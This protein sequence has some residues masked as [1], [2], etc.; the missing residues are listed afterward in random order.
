MRGGYDHDQR[1]SRAALVALVANVV[2]V[3][4]QQ[5]QFHVRLVGRLWFW[6]IFWF[7]VQVSKVVDI[8]EQRIVDWLMLSHRGRAQL[9]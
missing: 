8:V 1:D 3:V 6:I 7:S 4:C 2:A 5:E 9:G